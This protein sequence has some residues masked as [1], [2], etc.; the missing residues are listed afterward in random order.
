MRCIEADAGGS[1]ARTMSLR[2]LFALTSSD[3]NLSPVCSIFLRFEFFFGIPKRLMVVGL[4]VT[5]RDI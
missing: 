2:L 4:L 3:E 5:G 1:T